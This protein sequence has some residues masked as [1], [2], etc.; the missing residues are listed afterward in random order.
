[1]NHLPLPK[2]SSLKPIEV[3]YRCT[4]DY[5]GG[6]MLDY[7]NRRGWKIKYS[8]YGARYLDESGQKPTNAELESFIQT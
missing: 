5:D 1:M 2:N 4:S 8:P 6:P 3:P 7:P